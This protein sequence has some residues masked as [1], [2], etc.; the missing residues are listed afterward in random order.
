MLMQ[1]H[2]GRIQLLPALPSQWKDGSIRGIRARGGFEIDSMA[3]KG[4]KLTYVSIKSD[5][6]QTLNLVSGT[7]TFTTTTVPGKVYEFDGNLKLTNQPFE[8]ATIPGKIQAES[9]VAMDGV[10]IEDDEDGEPNLGWINDGDFSSYLINVPT[11]GTY[12]L[13]ARVASEAE[14]ASTITVTDSA[15]KALATLKVD[16][17]KTNGWN[18]W[19]ETS[20]TITLDKGEQTLKFDYAGTSNF[21]MN[22]DW[23]SLANGTTALPEATKVVAS[24]LEVR[25]VSMARASIALMVH[26]DADFEVRLYTVTGNLVAKRLGSGNALVEFGKD[27]HFTQGNYIAVVSSGK[28]RKTLKIRAY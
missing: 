20:T 11:A 24:T 22:I 19:Y 15:G 27:G 18:D 10:Q 3:W 25:P 26:S 23:F 6:G 5:V 7:N 9:Y 4:G 1:R 21:L 28:M 2:N 14:E 12:T 8:P 13:T 17:E 16:P